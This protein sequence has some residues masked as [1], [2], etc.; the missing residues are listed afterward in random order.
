MCVKFYEKCKHQSSIVPRKRLFSGFRR[1]P[2]EKFQDSITYHLPNS[3]FRYMAEILPLGLKK[4]STNQSDF[5]I[6]SDIWVK[7]LS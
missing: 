1:G 7:P 4:Q 5:N 3:R 6:F 2:P